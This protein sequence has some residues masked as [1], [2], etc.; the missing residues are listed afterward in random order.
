[1][2][3]STKHLPRESIGDSY[4]SVE[5]ILALLHTVSRK[6]GNAVVLLFIIELMSATEENLQENGAILLILC[7]L[8]L[9]L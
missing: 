3:K 7:K 9:W 2:D 1:M 5:D 8:D 6:L 4:N